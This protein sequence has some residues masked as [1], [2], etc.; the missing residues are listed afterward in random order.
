MISQ[1]IE[2]VIPFMTFFILWTILFAFEFYILQSNKDDVA[3]YIGTSKAVG[4]L[5]LAF[6][7][8]IGNINPPSV[9][10]WYSKHDQSISAGVLIFLVYA[11]WIMSQFILLMVL[12][13]FVIALVSGVYEQVMDS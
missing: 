8:G 1:S 13:N 10:K 2:K 7:N 3:G 5:L 11:Y 4:Y 9:G 12:L 6:E